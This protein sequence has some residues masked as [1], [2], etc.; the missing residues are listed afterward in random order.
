MHLPR[1]TLQRL[2]LS[3]IASCLLTAPMSAQPRQ[4]L[5]VRHAE[6]PDSDSDPNLTARGYARAAALVQ[7]FSS[8]FDTPDYLFAA[9]ASKQS[10]RPV[11]TL[12]PLATALHMKLNS[13][14]A[15]NDYG[16]LAQQI[17][18]DP[19]YTGKMLI[20]CWHHGNIPELAKA[21]G[22]GNPPKSWPD[23]VFD[24][25][26]RIQYTD[27]AASMENLPQRLLFGDSSN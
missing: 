18:T 2:L 11:E 1:A 27:G 12:T 17:L 6:K 9:Q 24:R 25:V 15:D 3:A 5:I 22:V 4:I 10:N 26:W 23:D 8:S 7:F 13:S 20:I 16:T 19:Q 14:I 21:L